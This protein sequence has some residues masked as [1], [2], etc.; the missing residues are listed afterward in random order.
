MLH[1]FAG[2]FPDI[3][4]ENKGFPTITTL[5]KSRGISKYFFYKF[6]AILDLQ[7][8]PR[9]LEDNGMA[10]TDMAVAHIIASQE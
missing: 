8:I 1:L 6:Y 5:L 4:M 3:T 10:G 7:S 9:E 2:K